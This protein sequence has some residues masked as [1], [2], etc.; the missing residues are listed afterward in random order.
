M[1]LSEQT[2]I[3]SQIGFLIG[4]IIGALGSWVFLVFFTNI[5]W[6]VKVLAC[7][8]EIGI[9]GSL[10]LSLRQS[11]LG[12]RNYLEV[13]KQMEAMT[14]AAQEVIETKTAGNIYVQ[15]NERGL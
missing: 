11:I 6:W 13:K 7:I 10:V 14:K 2:L 4:I 12:R 8:G 15:E 1:K 5:E 3:E 9:V